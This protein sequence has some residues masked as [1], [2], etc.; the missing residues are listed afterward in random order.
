M[1]IYHI[2][3]LYLRYH[4]REKI[5]IPNFI[6]FKKLLNMDSNILVSSYRKI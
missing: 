6:A 1:L 4:N 2:N 3:F 5:S